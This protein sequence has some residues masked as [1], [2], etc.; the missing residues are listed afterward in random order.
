MIDASGDIG[1][2]DAPP[3]KAGWRIGIFPD[4]TTGEPTR[5]VS[6]TNAALA[7]SGDS[8]QHIEIDGVRYSHIVD[9]RTGLGLTDRSTVTVIAKDC[10]TADSF[11]TAI[12]VL[13][14]KKGL[15]VVAK[16]P[17]V[18]V[19]I[20]RI[21]GGKPQHVESD[22]FSAKRGGR[23]KAGLTIQTLAAEAFLDHSKRMV[24]EP[25]TVGVA[26]TR[27][28]FRG[29]TFAHGELLR[30]EMVRWSRGGPSQ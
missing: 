3:G 8:R 28:P 24:G 25:A 27:L 16:T 26:G 29:V 30:A 4:P 21:D 15:A 19:A 22:G 13:G 7:V 1:V 11:A 6:L 12:S 20:E 10:T 17:G 9:P 23:P 5:Y 18:E 2:L 14:P